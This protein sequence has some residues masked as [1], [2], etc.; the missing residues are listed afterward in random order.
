MRDPADAGRTS[1]AFA[2]APQ[3][4]LPRTFRCRPLRRSNR[5]PDESPPSDFT[6]SEVPSTTSELDVQMIELPRQQT[7][8]H[9]YSKKGFNPTRGRGVHR[10][11]LRVSI[12]EPSYAIYGGVHGVNLAPGRACA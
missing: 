4:S 5:T 1:I 9:M 11:H 3:K 8:Q 6:A 12:D 7:Q 2:Q 10:Q